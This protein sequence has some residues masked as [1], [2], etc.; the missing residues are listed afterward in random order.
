MTGYQVGERVTGEGHIAVI[1]A[2]GNVTAIS[3]EPVGATAGS[4]GWGWGGGFLADPAGGHILPLLIDDAHPH[5]HAYPAP[6]AYPDPD[7]HADDDR[8]GYP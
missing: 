3:D 8:N 6:D 2:T 5:P 1:D 4:F 7:A